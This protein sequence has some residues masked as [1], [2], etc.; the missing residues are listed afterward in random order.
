MRLSIRMQKEVETKIECNSQSHKVHLS[1]CVD[2]VC[3]LESDDDEYFRNFT[4]LDS[5][6]LYGNSETIHIHVD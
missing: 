5:I 2:L 1:H 3:I 4:Y 6:L